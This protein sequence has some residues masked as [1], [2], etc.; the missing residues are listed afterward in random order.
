MLPFYFRMLIG[1]TYVG[2]GIYVLTSRELGLFFNSRGGTI[3]LGCLA[4]AYG[5]FRMYRAAKNWDAP[6]RESN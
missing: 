5:L 2:V 1:L 6:N 4:I 3:A